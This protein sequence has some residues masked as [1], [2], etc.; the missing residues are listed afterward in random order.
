[1]TK[2]PMTLELI[3]AC[4]AALA[5]VN[6][7]SIRSYG[8]F[9]IVRR[10][11][12]NG[13]MLVATDG[14]SLLVAKVSLEYID[15]NEGRDFALSYEALQAISKLK[16]KGVPSSSIA[17]EGATVTL[18]S[19]TG[20]KTFRYTPTKFPSIDS[21]VPSWRG[22]IAKPTATHTFSSFMLGTIGKVFSKTKEAVA[23]TYYGD[24]DPIELRA[25]NLLL[26]ALPQKAA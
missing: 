14:Y 24:S 18:H 15:S 21:V 16:P 9:A 26:I 22:R 3:E 7:T 2:Q 25:G 8:S 20:L 23:A 4:R 6:K 1:M 17:I 10:T 13:D 11:K 19:D 12:I 5:I